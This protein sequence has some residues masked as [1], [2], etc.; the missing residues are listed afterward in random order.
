[1]K[2]YLAILFKSKDF[3]ANTTEQIS[4]KTEGRKNIK[5]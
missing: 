5:K 4:W 2:V 1:M 3:V